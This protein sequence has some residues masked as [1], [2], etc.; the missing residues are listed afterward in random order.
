MGSSLR[1]NSSAPINFFSFIDIITGVTGVLI[2]V[3]LLLATKVNPAITGGGLPED[4]PDPAVRQKLEQ[5]IDQLSSVNITNQ[6][7]QQIVSAVQAAP[8]T[9]SLKQEISDLKQQADEA[10]KRVD[11][12]RV[13]LAQVQQ[14]ERERDAALGLDATS[15]Q[16]AELQATLKQLQADAQI[17]IAEMMQ[18]EA[19]VREAEARLLQVQ[20]DQNK[21]W[22]IPEPSRTSKEPLLLTISDRSVTVERFNKPE[23]RSVLQQPTERETIRALNSFSTVDYYIVFYVRPSGI[24]RFKNLREAC[25]N[26]GYEVGYD[27][28]EEQTEIAF[29]KPK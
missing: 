8:N 21:I 9:A 6:Q 20:R 2:L 28:I 4:E 26:E 27:A 17:A 7:L 15:R 11:G 14:R 1:G 10:R 23:S 22:V 18:W 29:S 3:T 13:E 19:K 25:K 12:L 24:V 16:L 5:L